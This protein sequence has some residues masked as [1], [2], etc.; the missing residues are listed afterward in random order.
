MNEVQERWRVYVEEL[1]DKEGKP[2]KEA[3]QLEDENMI[4]S[5]QQGSHI[6]RDE[7]YAAIKSI[8]SGK[9]AGVDDI[10]AE[11]LK[12][13]EGEALSKLEELCR[14]TYN[15]GIWPDD[16]TKSVMIQRSQMQWT[17]QI[18]GQ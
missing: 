9:A 4:G 12:M 3:S 13:L 11:F 18:T 8:K 15:T 6:S 10:P 1:N 2:V 7:I 16:F 17:V 5:D 14:E